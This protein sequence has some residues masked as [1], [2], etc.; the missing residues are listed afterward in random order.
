MGDNTSPTDLSQEMIDTLLGKSFDVNIGNR[1]FTVARASLGKILLLNEVTSQITPYIK[2]PDTMKGNRQL[3]SLYVIAAV[4]GMVKR[5]EQRA[6]IIR[7]LA[8]TL[9]NTRHEL[10]SASNRTQVEQYITS[11]LSDEEI[12]SLYINLRTFE[13]VDGYIK[14][15]GI[16][17]EIERMNKAQKVKKQSNTLIF[18]GV[19]VWGN[20]IDPIAERY[21]WTLDYILWGISFANI[22]MLMAD[23]RKEV[24]L[25][26]EER[27]K[28]HISTDGILVNGDDAEAVMAF[29]RANR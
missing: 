10:M 14:E 3:Q 25:T 17:R 26:D 21:G 18:C 7:S 5:P 22:R 29:I 11:H 13:D 12:A 6:L 28:A 27:K 2:V 8:I 24:Y 9:L 1:T 19:S 20:L 15:L 4:G 23:R 16:G